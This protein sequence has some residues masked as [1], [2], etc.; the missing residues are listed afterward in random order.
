MPKTGRACELSSAKRLLKA[1]S[2]TTRLTGGEIGSCA[3]QESSRLQE[4]WTTC[5]FDQW[6][7]PDRGGQ[8]GRSLLS[9]PTLAT[10]TTEDCNAMC[11]R[12]INTPIMVL[13]AIWAASR[14]LPEAVKLYQAPQLT[15]RERQAK[16]LA[17]GNVVE[18][19]ARQS[20][21]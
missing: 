8:E 20:M 7:R 15:G 9:I 21:D 13:E 12:N 16:A 6:M 3:T 2:L 1:Q 5:L 11:L 18:A 4:D 14:K 19:N 17:L 10:T